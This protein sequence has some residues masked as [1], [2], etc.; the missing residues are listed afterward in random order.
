M[1]F[2]KFNVFG[3]EVLYDKT[4]GI[5]KVIDDVPEEQLSGFNSLI[6]ALTVSK[7]S[8]NSKRFELDRRK[9]EALEA[10]AYKVGDTIKLKN[11]NG[12]GHAV[13]TVTGESKDLALELAQRM[14][15]EDDVRRIVKEEIAN[16]FWTDN[17]GKAQVKKWKVSEMIH[18]VVLHDF[19]VTLKQK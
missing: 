2:K 8:P 13:F 6:S 14:L 7:K 15:S 19:D 10:L 5:V 3:I 9:T 1:E 12:D 11:V 4:F 16:S 17:D 18:D